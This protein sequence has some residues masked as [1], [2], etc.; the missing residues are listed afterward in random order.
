MKRIALPKYSKVEEQINTISHGIGAV[1]SIVALCIMLLLSKNK[2]EVICSC[3]FGITLI[4]LYTVSTLYHGLSPN[5]IAKRYLRVVDHCM[6]FLLVIGT[7]TPI[8]LLAIGGKLGYVILL[9]VFLVA[10]IGIVCNIRNLE[11]YQ[12]VSVLCHLIIGWSSLLFLKR[13]FPNIHLQ[14]VGYLILGGFMYSVG[15]ILYRIGRYKKYMHSIFHFFC[16]AGSLFHF[17]LV[18]KCV[19]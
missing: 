12:L 10:S 13:L 3:I 1:L 5:N 4:L 6:V 19:L 17:L 2:L 18:I 14:G 7:Y 15:A 11:K 16:L 9:F 8:A